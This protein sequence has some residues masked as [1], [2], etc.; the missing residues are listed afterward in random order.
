MGKAGGT[1]ASSRLH[2]LN[3][4]FGKARLDIRQFSSLCARFDAEYGVKGSD[5]FG[6]FVPKIEG[7]SQMTNEIGFIVESL[8]P[9]YIVT[10]VWMPDHEEEEEQEEEGEEVIAQFVFDNDHVWLERRVGK[11]WWLIDSRSQGFKPVPV[12]PPKS[13]YGPVRNFCPY[14]YAF[15]ELS[16]AKIAFDDSVPL[17]DMISEAWNQCMKSYG[18]FFAL[19]VGM[20][21]LGRYD[22]PNPYRL[23]AL[24]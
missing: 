10:R 16:E 8:S 24:L 14:R 17:L 7:H 1:S 3:A 9:S 6:F 4:F 20:C 23:K 5:V 13:R 12:W 21:D 15:S 2:S 22:F 11:K 18:H 19:S